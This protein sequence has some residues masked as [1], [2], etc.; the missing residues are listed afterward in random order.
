MLIS[1]RALAAIGAPHE[2]RTVE[3]KLIHTAWFV[4]VAIH[5][6][7]LDMMDRA[8]VAQTR[9]QLPEDFRQIDILVNNAGLALGTAAAQDVDMEVRTRRQHLAH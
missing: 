7:T 1:S 8:A 5:C 4:Q 6:H 2:R 9:E 3:A